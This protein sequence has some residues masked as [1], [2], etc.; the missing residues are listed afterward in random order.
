MPIKVLLADDHT[1]VR[2][3]LQMVLESQGDIRVVA[4]ASNGIEVIRKVREFEPDVV[5]MDIA[6]PTMNG[7]EAT[8]R[9]VEEHKNIKVLILSM[10]SSVEDIFR[11]LQAGAIGYLLKESAGAEVRDAVYAANCGKRYLSRKVDDILIDSYIFERS[12]ITSK[13]PLDNLSPREKEVVQ[14]VAE[15]KSSSEIA[16][17]LFLSVKTVETYRSRVMQKLGLKDFAALIKF[18]LQNRLTS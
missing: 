6:M 3:G 14:L 10:Y 11:A 15:G 2:D 7:I 9:I 18:A 5:V 1:I 16:G 4:E 12:Q 13:S 8:R 17:I